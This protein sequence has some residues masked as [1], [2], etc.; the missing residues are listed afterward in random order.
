[1][2][3]PAGNVFSREQLSKLTKNK[4]AAKLNPAGRDGRNAKL[5]AGQSVAYMVVITTIPA[6]YGPNKHTFSAEISQAELLHGP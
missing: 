5:E 4:L 6:N 1:M 3:A 2:E